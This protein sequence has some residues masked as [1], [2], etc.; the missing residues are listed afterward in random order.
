MLTSGDAKLDS[1]VTIEVLDDRFGDA[2]AELRDWL[3]ADAPRVR[4]D[5]VLQPAGQGEMS[6]GA[7]KALEAAVM[8]KEALGMV[9][10]GVS[11]W[12]SARATA[13]RTK[14]RV[15]LGEKEVEID[16]ADLA[17]AAEVAQRLTRELGGV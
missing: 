15:K 6:N 5:A 13:Q 2:L 8:S 1:C 9:I 7:L 4:V 17:K 16:T 11:G 10:A 12:L 3:R 14:I